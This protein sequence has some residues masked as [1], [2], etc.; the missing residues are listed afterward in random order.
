M[1]RGKTTFFFSKRIEYAKGK[2]TPALLKNIPNVI[3]SFKIRIFYANLFMT[4]KTRF[5]D[6]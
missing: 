4:L 6:H 5:K 1:A 2:E 3:F